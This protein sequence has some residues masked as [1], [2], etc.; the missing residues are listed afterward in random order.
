MGQRW[1]IWVLAL[2]CPWSLVQAQELATSWASQDAKSINLYFK[3]LS[4]L[5]AGEEGH[6]EKYFLKAK[7]RIEK[8]V[9]AGLYHPNELTILFNVERLMG[10][11]ADLLKVGRLRC[12]LGAECIDEELI[13]TCAQAAWTRG[14]I[15]G[16][17]YF[18]NMGEW[19]LPPNMD[20]TLAVSN[21]HAKTGELDSALQA[22]G[23][24]F[25]YPEYEIEAGIRYSMLLNEFG[26]ENE[27][28]LALGILVDRYP[29][30][31]S[32]QLAR[33]KFLQFRSRE[34]DAQKAYQAI[35]ENPDFSDEAIAQDFESISAELIQ[36]QVPLEHPGWRALLQI[37][38]IALL[39]RPESAI[40]KRTQGELF[41]T[42]G[43][44]AEAIDAYQS[45]LSLPNGNRWDTY[46]TI[47]LLNVEQGDFPAYLQTAFDANEAFPEHERAPL[48]LGTA[49]DRNGQ[50]SMAISTYI[51]GLKMS[52][53][54]YQ[55]NSP[56]QPEY[57]FRLANAYFHEGDLENMSVCMDQVL[58]F[59][60]DH[61]QAKNNYAFYLAA[62][63][64]RLEDAQDMIQAALELEPTNVH[65]LDTYA[66]VLFKKGKWAKAEGIMGKC[67]SAGGNEDVDACL[68]AAEIAIC[69][70]KWEEAENFLSKAA[71]NGA[72]ARALEEIRKQII[73]N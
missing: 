23:K 4:I 46:E 20:R 19:Y 3:G 29:D 43:K 8:R 40:L 14:D 27:A 15:N 67:M 70:K 18:L 48:L 49:L 42:Q 54:H 6:P 45:S 58:G 64:I 36:S 26:L 63:G 28:N 33:A 57:L 25:S 35:Y 55:G 31:L 59:F 11:P 38:D 65:Y 53:A 13:T 56:L 1:I 51:M 62:F 47:A 10:E 52:L 61:A 24:L 68:H 21:L 41:R 34:E 16:A 17:I 39:A 2:S 7:K 72:S 44:L 71:S 22:I 9:Q 69:L 60:P 50:S 32:V 12:S 66:Y 37:M 73:P 5:E 30:V